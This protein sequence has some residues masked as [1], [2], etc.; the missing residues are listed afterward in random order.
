MCDPG[1]VGRHIATGSEVSSKVVFKQRP[2]EKV[3]VFALVGGK[4][5]MIEYSDLPTELATAR[6]PDGTLRF[7]AGNPAIHLFSVDFLSRVTG[8]GG[9]PFHVAK[10]AVPHFDPETGVVVDPGQEP[11]AL[12]FERF[13]FDA[14]PLAERWLAVEARREEEFAPLKN[15]TGADSPE[16]VRQAQLALHARWLAHAALIR[17]VPVPEW[18]AP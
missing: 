1:F 9:L 6:E 15:A 13:I 2:E 17:P 3:G 8:T 7:R 18:E 14:L 10:K 4:C 5:G 11:N 16:T 12:K